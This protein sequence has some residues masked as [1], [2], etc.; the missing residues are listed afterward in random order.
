MSLVQITKIIGKD[1]KVI[2]EKSNENKKLKKKETTKQTK[3]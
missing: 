1:G 2:S 3:V